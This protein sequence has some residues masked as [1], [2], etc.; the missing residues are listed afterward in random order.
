MGRTVIA[1]R[2]W[3]RAAAVISALAASVV[4]IAACGDT[5]GDE[6]GGGSSGEF[7]RNVT[8]VIPFGPGVGSD[9]AGRLA[10][11]VLEKELGVQ[12][13]V[14]NVPGATGNTGMTKM[15]QSRPG[16]A[17]AIMPADTL[18]TTVAGSSSF[19]LDEIK[20]VCRISNAPSSLWVNTKSK[21][22]SWDALSK[23]AKAN[24]GKIT[25][26]TVGKGGIDDIQLGA[27]AQ[28]GFK[29]KAVPFAEGTERKASVLSGD[30]D[31]IY[32]Q[33][34]DVKDNVKA[35]QFKPVLHFNTKRQPGLKGDYT[36]ASEL[37]IRDFIHQFR[38]L[39]ANAEMPKAQLD[40]L[41]K[42]CGKVES[43]PK[44]AD[45]QKVNLEFKGA[46]MNAAEFEQF[47]KSEADRMKQLGTE[48][49]VFK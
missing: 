38:G 23:A 25:V 30:S 24:P 44:F 41:S 16:E 3:K 15:L 9:Q 31:A 6:G 39:V 12:F 32:E 34:G 48:Y 4:G 13:P 11:P 33:Y 36:L 28:K 27:L 17:V 47:V 2:T 7:K 20:P 14:I 35:G 18:A 40:T 29:F 37:G 45:F 42:A 26:A 46:F 22:T 5:G 8:M 43:D 19:K 10:A 21:Y 49:G 1:K